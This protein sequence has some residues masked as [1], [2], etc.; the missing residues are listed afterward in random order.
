MYD[1]CHKVLHH[2][3][4]TA[5]KL[6]ARAEFCYFILA[7]L[8]WKSTKLPDRHEAPDHQ[9]ADSEHAADQNKKRSPQV[10]GQLTLEITLLK[11]LPLRHRES[12]LS[13]STLI[14]ENNLT[15]AAFH[16][17]LYTIRVEKGNFA[18]PACVEYKVP[19]RIRYALRLIFDKSPYPPRSEWKKPDGGPDSNHLWDDKE[20]VGRPS[21]ELKKRGRPMNAGPV[22]GWAEFLREMIGLA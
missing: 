6:W 9:P 15:D 3:V 16:P 8:E 12:I 4:L 19:P 5:F 10:L 14:N 17:K 20:F 21:D 18:E 11:G 13:R 2:E 22:E 1:P 7:G